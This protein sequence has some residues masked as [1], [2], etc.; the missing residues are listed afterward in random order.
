MEICDHATMV[1]YNDLYKKFDFIKPQ[2]MVRVP[3][4]A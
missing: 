2:T 1:L 4:G 3:S